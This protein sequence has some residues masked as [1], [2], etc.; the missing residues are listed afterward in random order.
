M[1]HSKEQI[2]LIREVFHYSHLFNDAVFVIKIDYRIIDH[3]LFPSLVKDLAL[4]H[5]MGIK[6]VIIPGAK[7]RI[8]EVLDRY[9][10]ETR[11]AE[12]VRISTEESIP[13]IKM[14]AFDVSNRIM[15]M[16]AGQK[17]HAVIGNW[18][19]ARSMG[20]IKG[21]DYQ[22][23]GIVE[24]IDVALVKKILAEGL[25]PVFPCIGWNSL[26]KPYNINSN[27][28]AT[29]ASI[30]LKAQKLFFV[31]PYPGL[32]E[33][34]YKIPPGAYLAPD[35]RISRLS[36]EAALEFSRLNADSSDPLLEYID[37]GCR[38]ASRQVDRVH[39]IDG[40][41]DG[42]ILKEIFSNL[43]MG[44]MI[45]GNIYDSIRSMEPRD[46]SDVLR[47]MEPL[48]EKEILVRRTE[49]QLNASYENYV[50]YEVD[51]S[52]HGCGAL[53]EFSGD[54]AE[55]AGIAVDQ[56]YK[57]LGIGQKIV[58]YLIGEARKRGL[59]RVFVLTTQTA[60]WFQ[61]L[62]FVPGDISDL[63]EDRRRI[64]DTKRKSKIFKFL[65]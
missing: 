28:L 52:I 45:H 37:F 19:R 18:V 16:L 32:T 54:T 47:L 25:I 46:V 40:T 27:E 57:H 14:A 29:V 12:G 15:T 59:G 44:M 13:F 64:Y 49:D 20:V 58:E 41:I 17:V 1:E 2:D 60:D 10:I 43:G 11:T 36:V 65:L 63:P 39:I 35:G 56:S 61:Q 3:P 21:L 26:G 23:T 4:L 30:S 55:I 9:G 34:A 62:G 24:K 8:E 31:T 6:M 51:D 5:Q 7:A 42:V 48:V 53:V 50:V 22:Q 33:S 38:A